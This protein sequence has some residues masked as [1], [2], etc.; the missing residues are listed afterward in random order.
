[1]ARLI[2]PGH[3]HPTASQR[4]WRKEPT[5]SRRGHGE[6]SYRK[7][8]NGTWE[9]RISLPDGSRPS[10]YGKTKREVTEKAKDLLAALD[11][12]IDV[13]GARRSMGE[14]LASWMA[15]V[16]VPGRR[17]HT[18][19]SY[20]SMIRLHIIPAIG[21]VAVGELRTQHVQRLIT[22]KSS[23]KQQD[24]SYRYAPGTVATILKVVHSSLQTAVR[25]GLVARNV[26]SVVEIPR[27]AE[28]RHV[29][30][31]TE[32]EIDRF[33]A[34]ARNDRMEAFYL[35]A[36]AVGLRRGEALG[37]RW[38]DVDLDAG[39]LRVRYQLLRVNGK[40]LT[41]SEP[42]TDSGKRTIRLPSILVDRLRAHR[43][44][45]AFERK[46]AQY[47]PETVAMI[48]G[49]I[50]NTFVFVKTTGYPYTPAHIS[51]RWREF[52]LSHD[53]R[54][55]PLHD[56]RHCC[57]SLL[58]RQGVDFVRIKELLGHSNI[59]TT[60]GT[61]VHLTREDPQEDVAK[62]MDLALGGSAV[63]GL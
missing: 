4:C 30:P 3:A 36:L 53:L 13:I 40:G 29:E 59:R 8:A 46:Q 45:Q 7:R 6:G 52:C 35:V 60:L 43:D 28:P 10:V 63:Q 26:A 12:G 54:L 14:F 19:V 48:D 5:V 17:M 50:P 31:F 56:V 16:V 58:Y 1:M 38:E 51:D 2:Q 24:G 11:D 62:Q 55:M 21:N 18:V 32:D 20:E 33:L 23:E 15:D 37:L 39:I 47:W 22:A 42:K 25:W 41:L 57:A 34:A 44:R 9:W 49:E 61:Y 27:R